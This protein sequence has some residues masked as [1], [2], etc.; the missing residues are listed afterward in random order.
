M[1]FFF[2]T[3][4]ISNFLKSDIIVG[5][6]FKVFFEIQMIWHTFFWE[7]RGRL[8]M[9]MKKTKSFICFEILEEG[10]K[11]FKL[12]F[13]Y[14]KIENKVT[15]TCKIF[16]CTL[17]VLVDCIDHLQQNLQTWVNVVNQLFAQNMQRRLCYVI[18]LGINPHDNQVDVI[19]HDH[20]ITLYRMYRI[21]CSTYNLLIF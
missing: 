4:I 13:S 21:W 1:E 3:K 10:Q 15:S 18:Q 20:F 2:I 12:F 5:D 16:A 8:E 11:F 14:Y 6:T 9:P 17:Q 7:T 19:E